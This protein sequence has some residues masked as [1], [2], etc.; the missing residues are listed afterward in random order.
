M[1]RI[2]DVKA[3][4]QTIDQRCPEG[5]TESFCTELNQLVKKMF[6]LQTVFIGVVPKVMF[7]HLKVLLRFSNEA[8]N[9][10]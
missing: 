8:L 4:N 9:V 6:Q 7:F 10:F 2:C 1:S 3:L 5:T